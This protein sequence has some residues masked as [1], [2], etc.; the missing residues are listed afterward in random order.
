MYGELSIGTINGKHIVI[1]APS[2]SASAFFNYSRPHSIVLLVE[3]DAQYR[4]PLVD[5]VDSGYHCDGGL[6]FHSAF[7][8]A[9]TDGTLPFHPDHP[10]PGT[11][12][13]S[14][15]FVVVG[16]EVFPLKNN[17]LRS[18][19]GRNLHECEVIFNYCLSRSP[20]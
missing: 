11:S 18:F 13:P 8:K 4:F 15:H 3:C 5:V 10:L 2:N 14:L 7:R 19:A 9:L 12:H 17:M 16:D 6:L 20:G 1:Q